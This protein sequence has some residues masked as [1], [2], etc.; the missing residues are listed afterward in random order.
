MVTCDEPPL[1]CHIFLPMNEIYARTQEEQI[2]IMDVF[3]VSSICSGT[4]YD[5]K[6]L[7]KVFLVITLF[8]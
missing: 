1:H 5:K 6:V 4:F 3:A 8:L 2:Y 7:T